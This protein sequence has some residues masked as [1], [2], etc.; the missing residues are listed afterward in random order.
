[1]DS[2]RFFCLVL[3]QQ[4]LYWTARLHSIYVLVLNRDARCRCLFCDD[5]KSLTLLSED[6]RHHGLALGYGASFHGP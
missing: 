2:R 1:M 3:I 4:P 6:F 5:L